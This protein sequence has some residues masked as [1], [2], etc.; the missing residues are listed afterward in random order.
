MKALL[1]FCI[2]TAALIPCFAQ[3]G[4]L[5]DSSTQQE[6]IKA[7]KTAAVIKKEPHFYVNLHG[8]YSTAIGSTYSY[9]PDNITSVQIQKIENNPQV[10][11]TA[12]KEIKNGLGNGSRFGI[13]VY[14]ILNDF[15]NIGFDLDFFKTSISKTRDSSYYRIET[16]SNRVR[17]TIFN[18]HYL[19]SYNAN[20][21]TL[22]PM[23]TFK[24]ISR[25]KWFLYNKLGAM[26]SLQLKL[27][28]TLAER[29]STRKGTNGA[30]T[31]S[32]ANIYKTFYFKGKSPAWGFNAS[33]G[34]QFKI[35]EKVRFFVEAQFTQIVFYPERRSTSQFMLNGADMLPVTPVVSKEIE[36]EKEYAIVNTNDNSK[37]LKM[38]RQKVPI[39]YVGLM[40]GFGIRL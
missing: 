16:T 12:Y 33:L 18:Q 14:Y 17:E 22:S 6:Q 37:P 40:A 32:V 4:V 21:V 11:T 8:G 2:I 38:V 24:A 19:V 36:F 5:P 15:I 20:I 7:L 1:L 10:K 29:D 9:F 3:T 39:S 25:P 35:T 23:V 26:M 28:E 34:A 13:G 27:D 31:D 30:Y